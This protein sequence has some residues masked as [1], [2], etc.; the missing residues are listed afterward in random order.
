MRTVVVGQNSVLFVMS[1]CEHMP[2]VLAGVN[3]S[4][5]SSVRTVSRSDNIATFAA[6][7]AAFASSAWLRPLGNSDHALPCD[8]GILHRP[9]MISNDFAHLLVR[10]H[11]E[12]QNLV[13]PSL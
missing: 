12:P 8:P 4:R 5:R 6:S 11:L 13:K 3:C 9:K 2:H 1:A 7:S 10:G